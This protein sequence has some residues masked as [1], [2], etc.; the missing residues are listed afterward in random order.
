MTRWRRAIRVSTMKR[1]YP[2]GSK[3]LN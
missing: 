3:E 2:K 1:R